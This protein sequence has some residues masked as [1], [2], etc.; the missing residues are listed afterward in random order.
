M[1]NPGDPATSR[2]VAPV[3]RR[4]RIVEP[5]P[6][7]R[8]ATLSLL[9]ATAVA[10][11]LIL[12]FRMGRTDDS[13]T[14]FQ[15]G[16]SDVQLDWRCTGAGHQFR[17]SGQV[18]PRVCPFCK[19]PSFPIA[20]FRCPVHEDLEVWA[21]FSTVGDGRTRMSHLKVGDNDWVSVGQEFQCPKC[22]R[23]LEREKDDPLAGRSRGRRRGG[24]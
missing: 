14:A 4:V 15:R 19:S 8:T 2:S 13:Q 18:E 12:L 21:R 20:P 1:M 5:R 10:L 24:N 3:R 23:P 7:H 22:A 16:L 6:P 17:L 11:A 9:V